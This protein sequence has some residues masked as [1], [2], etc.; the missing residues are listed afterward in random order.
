MSGSWVTKMIV[1]PSWY[2]SVKICITSKLAFESRLPVGS[3]AIII[4]GSLANALAMATR[5]RCP[6]DSSAG[7]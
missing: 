6:P 2:N 4:A 7:I 5:C 3:S 1:R